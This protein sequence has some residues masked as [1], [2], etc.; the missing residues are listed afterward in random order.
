[1]AY[2]AH[3]HLDGYPEARRDA[4]LGEAFAGGVA[5]VVAVSMDVASCEVNRAWAR[6]YPGRVMPAY[7]HHPEQP[8]LGE[9]A[10]AALCD[11]IRAR[12][13]DGEPFA[14]GEVG[15]P[16]YTRTEAEAKGEPFDE[17]PY[18]RQLD[19]FVALAAELDRPIALH[20][21][22]EDAGKA[23]DL[24]ERRG[25]RR[26]HFHWFKGDSRTVDRIVA[27]GYCLSLTPDVRYEP[28][29]RALAAAVP[30][31]RLMAE[32]DGPWPFEGP[33]AG[34][35]THPLMAADVAAEIAR[36]RGLAPE[37]VARILDANTRSFYGF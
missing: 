19:R 15:L 34:R 21:V 30:L 17:T 36:L 20:A 29:I 13:A 14:V 3:L 5:G 23:L 28:E 32:T 4:L 8:P 35:E 26:A 10:L 11:W 1:M 6:R 7:G 24:L 18:A 33:Y 2:D 16:Y 27:N 31:E 37:A 9:A 22:Y 25:I 12:A